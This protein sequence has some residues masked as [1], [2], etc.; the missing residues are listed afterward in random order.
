MPT[1]TRTERFLYVESDQIPLKEIP[2]SEIKEQI[3]DPTT[4]H[5]YEGIVMEGCFADLSNKSANN[6]R[7]FYDVPTYLAL[8]RLLKKQIHSAKGLY[9]ELEHPETYAVN[10]NNISHKL[11]DVWF[12][13]TEQKVYGRILL[14]NT[15]TGKIA[16]E[17]V[18]SG[19]LLAISGRA[20]GDEKTNPDGTKSAV[21]K[22]L[23]T[24][25]IVY[26]PGFSDA[27]LVYKSL[28][29]SQ[30]IFQEIGKSK[31]GFAVKIYEKDLKEISNKFKDYIILNESANCFYEWYYK[32]LNEAQQEQS[33]ND[34]SQQETEKEQQ[35]LEKNQTND[36]EELQAKLSVATQ[37]DLSEAK[38]KFI[39]QMKSSQRRLRLSANKAVFDDSAGFIDTNDTGEISL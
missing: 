20:A 39:G 5:P 10:T 12:D 21:A 23:T 8:L 33:K 30:Q 4:G 1:A 28:N 38:Q 15:P 36:E 14:L 26:H 22:L 19:G 18:K 24:F 35:I 16:Q 6:N 9:G 3:I 13:D 37:K 25:D 29:E 32:S 7:R 17:I 27:I 34:D 11:L 2:F 31:Q